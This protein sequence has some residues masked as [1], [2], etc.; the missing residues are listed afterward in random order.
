MPN[1]L[2]L[3]RKGEG[4]ASKP[5]EGGGGGGCASVVKLISLGNNPQILPSPLFPSSP[6][7]TLHCVKG[8]RCK[9]FGLGTLISLS[10]PAHPAHPAHPTYAL[11]ANLLPQC[12]NPSYLTLILNVKLPRLSLHFSHPW[13][14]APLSNP[15]CRFII[16][17][18]SQSI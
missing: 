5:L 14:A 15:D 6:I 3:K 2:K 9:S 12:N 17:F 4:C 18:C 1:T 11:T 10:H 16:L 7:L 8:C 13:L